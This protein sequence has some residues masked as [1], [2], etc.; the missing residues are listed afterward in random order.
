MNLKDIFTFSFKRINPF[1]GL[2]ID[3]DTWRDAHN[4]SRDQLRLHNLMFHEVGIVEGLAVTSNEPQDLSVNIHPGVAIDSEGNTIIVQNIYHYQIQNRDRGTIYLII[5]FREILEG[6]Y[7]PPEGGQPTRILDGYRIQER[8]NLPDEPH[9][10]LARIDLDT[11]IGAIRN[12]ENKSRPGKNE[13]NLDFRKEVTK[14]LSQGT[15]EKAMAILPEIIIPRKRILIGYFVTDSSESSIH[16]HGLRN[17]TRELEMRYNWDVE[18]E[19]NVTLDKNIERFSLIYMTGGKDFRLNEAQQA[20]L[21]GFIQS[22]G[23]LFAEDCS[24]VGTR[25]MDSKEHGP[26]YDELI[27]KLKLKL[28]PVHQEASILSNINLFSE[29][30]QGVK[31]SVFLKNDVVIYSDNDYGCAWQGG[32]KGNPLSREV[33]RSTFEIGANIIEYAYQI[34]TSVRKQELV[35]T[36]GSVYSG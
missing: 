12:A 22:N 7:Q 10:E 9:L 5:Q 28:K 14:P 17:L 4:Y 34:K 21:E 8:D 30:P 29:I 35:A 26:V 31:L 3:A 23:V 6:P 25:I 1:P 19:E 36:D 33:I 15:T 11:T 24:E 16:I 27:R 2:A 32:H 13:I 20:S 18:L